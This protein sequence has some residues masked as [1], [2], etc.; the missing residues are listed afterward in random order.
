MGAVATN[1]GVNRESLYKMLSGRRDPRFGTVLRV[2]KALGIRLRAADARAEVRHSLTTSREASTSEAPPKAP[3][4][5]ESVPA[6]YPM[7]Y[8]GRTA[9]SYRAG[10]CPLDPRKR[11][12]DIVPCAP[13]GAATEFS[14]FRLPIWSG[15]QTSLA[16]DEMAY[17]A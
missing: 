1:A 8:V 9:Y 14:E 10:V 5:I 4:F 13:E 6:T 15:M 17:A 12:L 7:G 11:C 2:L 3:L 16:N